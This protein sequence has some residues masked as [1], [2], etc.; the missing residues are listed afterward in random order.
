MKNQRRQLGTR[1]PLQPSVGARG[2]HPRRAEDGVA[3]ARAFLV[4]VAIFMCAQP[5]AWAGDGGDRDGI[6]MPVAAAV[7]AVSGELSCDMP[8]A[9][10]IH[11]SMDPAVRAKLEVGLELAAER[12]RDIETCGDLFTRLGADGLDILNNSLYMQV[13][14]HLREVRVCGRNG[15]ARSLGAK[16]LAYTKVGAASTWICRHFSRVSAETAAIALIHEALHHAGLT[17]WPSDRLA[18]TSE[19]ITKMVRNACEF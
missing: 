7:V 8:V 12:V 14:N 13:N 4:L 5:A 17:E 10:F 1:E 18:M 2:D 6:M 9:P 16:N 19:Q 3:S 15:A 11:P